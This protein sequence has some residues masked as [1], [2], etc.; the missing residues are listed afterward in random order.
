MA[1]NPNAVGPAKVASARK[2]QN[3]ELE[4]PDFGAPSAIGTGAMTLAPAAA[5]EVARIQ[6]KLISAKSYPR[7]PSL[8]LIKI[9]SECGRRSVAENAT[10]EYSRGGALV[11][12]PSI[13]IAE[14]VA[15][16][17]GNVDYGFEEME[18]EKGFS[19]VRAFAIDYE[20]NT[21]VE[22]IFQ[23]EHV[24]A[25]KSGKTALTDPRDIYEIIANNASRRVRACILEIIPGDVIDY[26][27][28][29]CDETLAANIK[30]T[31][32]SIAALLESFQKYGVT[33][34][35]I[36][37]FL[38]RNIEAISIAQYMKLRGIYVS[39]KDGMAK[40]EDFFDRNATAD[41]VS[42]ATA[43]EPVMPSGQEQ[44]MSEGSSN[45]GEDD[46]DDFGISDLW[47]DI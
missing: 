18:S 10:Y 35:M 6:G 27:M 23:V 17:W 1:Y 5:R 34:A 43:E 29:K 2:M 8:A 4:R 31:P 11:K 19:K 16:C 45:A 25:T 40:V 37:A 22:R 39:L 44:G 14:A 26:A 15:R 12:G 30:I 32:D 33:K 21:S 47:G 41:A 3:S 7:D 38:Q 46:V 20:S 28:A 13:R 42:K 36:E 24:R 9:E